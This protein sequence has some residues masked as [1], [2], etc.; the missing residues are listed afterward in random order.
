MI[1]R[2]LA[3]LVLCV[4]AQAATHYV[5]STTGVNSDTGPIGAPWQTLAYAMSNVAAGDTVLLLRGDV[6]NEALV[7]SQ[8]NLTI[9]AYGSGPAPRIT[10]YQA[11]T[12]WTSQGSNVWSTPMTSGTSCSPSAGSVLFNE[13]VGQ[14]QSAQNAVLHDR[15]F[16]CNS[17][18]SIY[19]YAASSPS[20]YYGTVVAIT[21]SGNGNSLISIAGKTGI[22]IQHLQLDYFDGYGVYVSGTAT[23]LTFANMSVNGILIGENPFVTI[24]GSRPYGFYVATGTSATTI[25]FVNVDA[26]LNYDG[27][28]FDSY[29]AGSQI[30][31]TGCRAFANRDVGIFDATT[32]TPAVAYNYTHLYANGITTIESTDATEN[33][34]VGSGNRPANEAPVVQGLDRFPA[35][36]SFTI[37]DVGLSAGTETYIDTLTPVFDARG[38]KMNMAATAGYNPNTTELAAWLADGH[39]I[40]SHSWSHQYYTPTGGYGGPAVLNIQYGPVGTKTAATGT[41][42]TM[43][44]SANELTTTVTGGPGGQN[45]SV[46]LTGTHCVGTTGPACDTL[47]GLLAYI[48]ANYGN[49]YTVSAATTRSDSPI[50]TA[51]LAT[52][53]AQDIKFSSYTANFDVTAF[54][55]DELQSSKSW[56]ES[57]VSGLTVP[58]YVYPGGWNTTPSNTLAAT[59]GYA[60]GRGQISMHPPGHTTVTPAYASDFLPTGRGVDVYN[61]ISLSPIWHGLT[62]SQIDAKVA[63]LVYRAKAWGVPFGLFAHNTDLLTPQEVGWIL[64]SILGRHGQIKKNSELVTYLQRGTLVSGTTQYLAPVIGPI[65][66]MRAAG[67]SPEHAAG[68]TVGINDAIKSYNVDILG[69]MRPLP[70]TWD[71]GA[72]PSA[73]W[74]TQHGSSGTSKTTIYGKYVGVSQENIYCGP[75]D[76]PSFGLTDGPASLPQQCTYTAMS[77]TPSPG[78]VRTAT[79]CSDI[80]TKLAA[81]VNNS[82]DTVVIPASLGACVGTWA[83]TYKGDANHW[84]TIRTDQ[85]AN[86]NFPAEGVQ[87]TPCAI[88]ITHIDGY[89]DYPCASRAVLMPTLSS[90]STNQSTLNLTACNYCRVIGLNITKNYGIG[91]VNSLVVMDGSNHTILDRDLVHGDNWD[92]HLGDY[93]KGYDYAHSTKGGVSA[94]GTYQ[95]VI[96]SWVYDIDSASADGWAIGGG[97][98]AQSDEGPLKLY[99][100]LLAG[101]AET[102]MFGGGQLPFA[103]PHDFEFRRNLS[104]KPLKWMKARGHNCGG[105]GGTC[106]WTKNLGEFKYGQRVLYEDNV[107]LNNWEG[108]ADQWGEALLFFPKNQENEVT[109]KRVNTSV[110]ANG[111]YTNIACASDASGTPCAAGA[112]VWG[113]YINDV[114]R[115]NGIV[116]LHGQN[117]GA[118]WPNM[119]SAPLHIVVQG[120]PH[121]LV[122]GS[123]TVYLDSLNGEQTMGCLDNA[124][125]INCTNGFS[126]PNVIYFTAAGDDFGLT[127]PSSGMVQPFTASICPQGQCRFACND[128]SVTPAVACVAGTST[129]FPKQHIASVIDT[130]HI[131]TVEDMGAHTGATHVSCYPGLAPYSKVNDMTIRYNYITHSNSIGMSVQNVI[132]GCVDITPGVWNVS[133]HDNVADDADAPA[134]SVDNNAAY[135]HGATGPKVDNSYPDPTS[136]PHDIS[137]IHNTWAGMR[138]WPNAPLGSNWNYAFNITDTLPGSYFANLTIRDN[139]FPGPMATTVGG[140]SLM[141]GGVTAGFNKYLCSD[142]IGV[143]GCT[144]LYKN[145]LMGTAV[146]GSNYLQQVNTPYPAKNPDNSDVCP[147]A[148]FPN[149]CNVTDFSTVFTNWGNGLGDTSGKDYS[150][151]LAYQGKASDG[152]NVGADTAH[153]KTVRDALLPHFTYTALTTTA[154]TMTCTHA[155]YCEQQL[156]WSGGASPFVQWHL[157][158]VALC[159]TNSNPLPAGM[160]LANGDG[161]STCQVNGTY[162]KNGTTG[163]AGWVWGTPTQTGSFSLT[164]QVEDAAHQKASVNLTLTVN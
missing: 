98:G 61:I 86:P 42:A 122:S 126:N 56:L 160:N 92:L 13:V 7:I 117:N 37:D 128:T 84:L 132:N 163:C 107:F 141:A 45:L 146:N 10:G 161:F 28:R 52:V 14:R 138:G 59:A 100:N 153:W 72:Y 142:H 23:N 71:I 36:F 106:V 74:G 25:S 20:T 93:P 81:V 5:S 130:E 137:Y 112:G 79:S 96:N 162:S 88:N 143:T 139:I 127:I 115:T 48:T 108:Q 60:G 113:H 22:T 67:S 78:T 19:V 123:T 69:G 125:H 76:V 47:Q 102:W 118:V 11:L 70:G 24:A 54:W 39:D 135:S 104:M 65:P 103:Y 31:L 18:T 68:P 2:I 57:H 121:T 34:I 8:N 26:H 94:R 32:G 64:D 114:A 116:T 29:G 119:Y 55:T 63:A 136:W 15:D 50:H 21:P 49:V 159:G 109:A 35:L 105:N 73:L 156:T 120:L 51:T 41:A 101:A 83:P 147:A 75:G 150:V 6:W 157:C 140:G 80:G 149:G 16:W 97:T 62:Q 134:W 85:I 44:I 148:Q 53:S 111:K 144:W 27:F 43:S 58:V 30:T 155:V 66:S 1:R 131:T 151:T 40:D 46:N 38:L 152:T 4:C 154:Q 164:F 17:G 90:G 3:L 9:D 158:T 133:V 89:P 12:T 91:M 82:G 124:N 33:V 110:D 99:N 129:N 95:A 77:G 87:A 145:N